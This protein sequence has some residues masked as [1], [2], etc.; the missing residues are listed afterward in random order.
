MHKFS[1]MRNGTLYWIMSCFESFRSVGIKFCYQYDTSG[2]EKLFM[3][4]GGISNMIFVCWFCKLLAFFLLICFIFESIVIV[5]EQDKSWRVRY[6]VA[7]QL[8]ELC[9]AVG[10]EPTRCISNLNCCVKCICTFVPSFLF[11]VPIQF[12]VW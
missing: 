5:S 6:M 9:E 4:L 7:N 2:E 8:Y 10:P 1:W 12:C 11:Q 3:V